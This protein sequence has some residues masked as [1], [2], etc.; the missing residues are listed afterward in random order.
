MQT[1][2]FRF[3]VQRYHATPHGHHVN[4]GLVEWPPSPWRILRSLLAVGYTKLHWRDGALPIDARLLIEKLSA[5]LPSYSA[6]SL[7]GAHTRHYM[8][9]GNFK[10][11]KE[12]TTLV[13]DTWAKVT[14]PL[15]VYW[16]VLLDAAERQLL[17]E[18]LRHTNY[19]GRA[20]SWVEAELLPN[21]A[22]YPAP[23][24]MPIPG[25][26]APARLGFEQVEL[27]A[28]L[29]AAEYAG[30]R[31]ENAGTEPKPKKAPELKRWQAEQDIYP[32]DLLAALHMQTN[33]RRAAG[34]SQ[35]PGS[36]RVL[37]WRPKMTAETHHT[38][39]A[40]SSIAP[41]SCMLFAVAT[42]SRNQAA[43]PHIHRSLPHAERLHRAIVA[44][45]N[46]RPAPVL[47]GLAADGVRLMGAHQ[48]AHVLPL[49][50]DGDQHIDHFLLWAPM[51]FDGAAQSAVEAVRKT[52]AKGL[53][54]VQL[55]L[56]ARCELAALLTL[57][58]GLGDSINAQL[59]LTGAHQIW[60]SRTPLVLP[61][62]LKRNGRNTVEGQI[63]AELLARELPAAKSIRVID[64]HDD[65]ALDLRRFVRRRNKTSNP[66]PV[67]YGFTIELAF[68][69]PV[70]GPICLGYGSHLGLGQFSPFLPVPC[71]P[72]QEAGIAKGS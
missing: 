54:A 5:A 28:P 14:E 52:Y 6:T 29:S 24:C 35:A 70:R 17:S 37:Y 21:S 40:S 60:R 36:Q 27:M 46:G 31:S 38:I 16:P 48:H 55:A 2:Q 68:E 47:T 22:A 69:V 13:F 61:R 64:P 11:S 32:A 67:D 71:A 15:L 63:A 49:D 25:N 26:R 39:Q 50:L 18:L 44:A 4:E 30:W 33:T 72:T 20:E 23:L 1:L 8:P 3:P 42:D 53:G 9:M 56:I 12:Q 58:A 57:G 51:Q 19:L 43:L 59:G 65:L 62:Y 66:P 7:D 10:N 34:W 41:V 45:A